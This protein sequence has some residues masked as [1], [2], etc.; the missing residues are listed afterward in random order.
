MLAGHKQ[1]AHRLEDIEKQLAD[2]DVNFKTVFNALKQLLTEN[3]KSKR[4]RGV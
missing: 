3:E 4:K 2:Y 1:F